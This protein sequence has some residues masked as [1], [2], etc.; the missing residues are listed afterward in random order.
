MKDGS[1]VKKYWELIVVFFILSF[2]EWFFFR[3]IIGT[4]YG[5]LF[6]DRGDGRLTTLLTEHWWNFFTGKEKFSEIAMFYPAEEA[7]GYTDLLL[8]YGL[9]H[10]LLRLMGINMFSAYKW[11]IIMIHCMGTATMYYLLKK[12]L[13]I[14]LQWALFGTLA[15]SFSDTYARDL[16]HTQLGAVSALP[17]LLILLIGFLEN[18]DSRMKRNIYAYAFIGWF[19]LLT[20]NSWYIAYFTG[21]F[22]LVFLIVYLIRLK[23]RGLITLSILKQKIICVGKDIIGYLLFL[24]VLYLPFIQIYLPVLKASSGY[25]YVNCSR[26]LP[27]LID[28]INV[29]EDNWMLGGVIRKLQLLDRGYSGEVIQG[30]SIILLGFFVVLGVA[31]I[32]KGRD[33]AA[34]PCGQRKFTALLADTTFTTIFICIIL[35]IR[36]GSN[37]VSLWGLVYYLIPMAKSV[38][39][40]ARFFLWLSF[41]M[42]VTTAYMADRHIHCKKKGMEI[43]VSVCAVAMIFVSNI[44]IRGVSQHWNLAEEQNFIVNVSK[45]PED[46][47]VFY[48]IDIAQTGDPTYIYHLDAFEIATWYSL[49]TINGY[50]GQYPA[51]WD[52]IQHVCSDG[53]EDSV[54]Q[55]VKEYG[56][57]HVYAYDR[58][59]NIW[60]PHADRVSGGP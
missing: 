59:N 39:A 50:S 40:V 51:G 17:V 33:N 18:F 32:R 1:G 21:M 56:L 57:E 25:S 53:Y 10:S 54:D 42:A 4:G 11:T 37:G 34:G 31:G 13:N 41:P 8:G 2:C 12:K 58:A 47:Q 49:K 27:E 36:L 6:G 3:N 35:T 16:C 30:F 55:W 43:C 23:A 20:Y 29:S 9:L 60:I 28:I 44:N 45:P 14:R 5:A 38:R 7:F 48:I 22:C 26:A 46:A 24:I 19:V 15:F 52:G